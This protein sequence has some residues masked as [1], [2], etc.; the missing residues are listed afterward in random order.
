MSNRR[1]AAA[2]PEDSENVE[3]L[4]EE[5]RRLREDL[6]ANKS[7]AKGLKVKAPEPFDGDTS[8]LLP[9]FLFQLGLVFRANPSTY[10]T[11]ESKVIYAMSYLTGSASAYVQ[12]YLDQE[13][14]PPWMAD[15][16]SFTDQL[17]RVFGNPDVIG[18]VS[19]K[20]RRLKQT[21][22]VTSYATKFR[23]LAG[24]LDWSNAGLVSQ[25]FEGL[26]RPLQL[27]IAKTAYPKE[28][29]ELIDHAVRVDNLLQSYED[30]PA[31]PSPTT[32]VP[33]ARPGQRLTEQQRELRRKNNL[34]MY[35]GDAGHL[36][37]SCPV[38]PSRP[39]GPPR[40]VHASEAALVPDKPPGKAPTQS[41]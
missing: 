37:R 18:D 29:E 20:I 9:T 22:R 15:F 7:P 8:S 11:E 13:E 16:P 27:E 17:K 34:C 12:Q 39:N 1:T 30:Y 36:V 40:P 19:R 35:C 33:T 32:P 4:R 23:L 26:S 14:S 28:L 10:P 38:R 41:L 5:I 21:G 24:Q 6:A 3:Q 25:F 2:T 31:Q